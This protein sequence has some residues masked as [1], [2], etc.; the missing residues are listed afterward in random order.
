MR[1]LVHI[2]LLL[3]MPVSSAFGGSD[4]SRYRVGLIYG[5][6]NI[7][8]REWPYYSFNHNWGITGG[9]SGDRTLLTFSLLSQKN[10]GDSAASGHFGFFA[11]EDNAQLV[12][13]SLRAGFDLDYRLMK[14]RT[15]SPTIGVG[16]GYV[17]W[18]YADPAG[19]T[20][21][22]TRGS[23]E[24][25][26]HYSAAEMFLSGSLGLE[27]EASSR[28]AFNLKTSFDYLTGLGTAF[29]DSVNDVRGRL[30]MR[31]GISLSYRFGSG[32]ASRPST[33]SWPSTE[34]WSQQTVQSREAPSAGDA[35]GDGIKDKRDKC[36]GTPQGAVVDKSGCPVD[37][38]GDGVADGLDDCPRTPRSAIGYVDIFG[39]PIDAD[40]DGVPDYRD[41][42]RP[43]PAGVT[44]NEDGCPLDS[45]GDGV[46]DG[47]DDCPSTQPGIEVDG[48]GCIDVAFMNDTMRI[49]IEYQSGSFEI[50]M[51]TR[52]R[53]QPLIRKLKILTDVKIAIL[54][55][56]DNVGPAEAN[57]SLSQKRANRLRD[58]LVT[59]GIAVERLTAIGK[60]ETNFI[61]SNQ[62]AAG[63]A[64]NRRI[65]L[66]F[67]L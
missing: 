42:C 49:N 3:L 7:E 63:R 64:E 53:L 10:C 55:F 14:D 15:Y 23:R 52:D 60:G 65:E 27:I 13:K 24:N 25:I 30:L 56:T 54:G 11:S 20:V 31:L 67:S 39:C 58:W 6:G 1:I 40:F 28:L 50:D 41:N 43:S 19:D 9:I 62:T 48:R 36:P 29:S 45:D 4:A 46:Y 32:Q 33:E 35:D 5:L 61:A 59:Q 18:R 21:V 8:A 66:I 57:Q 37:S 12:F 34:A 47:R 51:R 44:V 38:D 22:Q 17:I 2:L 16:L 26:V